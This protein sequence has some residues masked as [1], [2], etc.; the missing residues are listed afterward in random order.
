MVIRGIFAIVIG[1]KLRSV[2]HTAEEPATHTAS[3]A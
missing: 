3:Y 1:F 2:R